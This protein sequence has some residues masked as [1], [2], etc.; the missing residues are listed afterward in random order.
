MMKVARV[1]GSNVVKSEMRRVH[2]MKKVLTYSLVGLLAVALLGGTA[3]ILLNRTETHTG[4]R[5]SSGQQG[6]A[7]ATDAAWGHNSGLAVA[8]SGASGPGAAGQSRGASG[9][10]GAVAGRGQGSSGQ[11]RSERVTDTAWETVVGKVIAV[12]SEITIRTSE[13]EMSVGM[14]QAAYRQGFVLEIGDEVSVTGYYEGGEFKAGTI[15]NLTTGATLVL[16]DEDGH[17][18]WSGRGRSGIQG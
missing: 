9:Y 5:L 10:D 18:M 11:G 4:T 3:Y 16:R 1:S 17:P 6:R 15:E 13:G 7:A 2:K 8:G 14:G 12:D